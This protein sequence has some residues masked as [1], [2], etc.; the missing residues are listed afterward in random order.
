MVVGRS[1][2]T[3]WYRT[4]ARDGR[5]VVFAGRA[6]VV[7]GSD[8]T[9]QLYVRDR[10]AVATER[11]SVN[12]FG[13]PADG[14]SDSGVISVAAQRGVAITGD[15]R[16]TSDHGGTRRAPKQYAPRSWAVGT[17][18]RTRA[19]VAAPGESEPRSGSR[20]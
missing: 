1:A 6:G 3:V 13:Q 18:G 19:N 14:S 11:V 10:V 5:Y 4:G 17:P 12:L 9:V 8:G 2:A 15:Q 7:G 20:T 16:A